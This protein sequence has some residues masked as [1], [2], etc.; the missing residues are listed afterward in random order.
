MVRRLL[1]LSVVLLLCG[2]P[3][4]AHAQ[5]GRG[6]LSV[7]YGF[8]PVT[9]WI[10]AYSDKLLGVLDMRDASLESWGGISVNYTFR[11]VGGLGVGGTFVYSGNAQRLDGRKVSTDYYSVLPH[12][13][14]RWLDLRIFSL[15]SRVG[16]GLT[17]TRSSGGGERWSAR[18]LAFQVSPLGI[19]V[20]GRLALYAEA[21]VGTTGSLVA[22][23]RFRF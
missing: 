3:R 20:G 2:M 19:E 1:V 16:A 5:L 11:I 21:G 18:Q 13:K 23:M 6:E 17:F 8:A 4:A 14:M 7:G 22:G 9:N 15:Y 10:S 12:L